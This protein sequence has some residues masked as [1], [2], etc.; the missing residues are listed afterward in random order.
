M[1]C[2]VRFCFSHWNDSMVKYKLIGTN[3]WTDTI[4]DS[5]YTHNLIYY[6]VFS[7]L[8]V[9]AIFF[10]F[11]SFAATHCFHSDGKPIPSNDS[12]M[13]IAFL[14][15]FFIWFVINV[16]IFDW[17]NKNTNVIMKIASELQKTA[18]C[19]MQMKTKYLINMICSN[20]NFAMAIG[21][22]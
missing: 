9:Q 17:C 12:L 8:F 10:I 5:K 14:S 19:N 22:F 3:A 16:H 20:H 15:I 21:S 1:G 18:K 13:N 2:F 7:S 6:P 11:N 4:Y